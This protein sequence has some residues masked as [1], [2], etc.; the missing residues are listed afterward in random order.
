MDSRSVS[1][2]EVVSKGQKVGI[3]GNTGQSFGQHLHFKLHKGPW[4]TSKS[5]SVNP[6]NIIPM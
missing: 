1:A 3:M 4:N 6:L 5:N 2:G